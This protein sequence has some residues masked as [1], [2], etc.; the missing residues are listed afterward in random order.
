MGSGNDS[1]SGLCPGIARPDF[2]SGAR[3]QRIELPGIFDHDR[4]LAF[5]AEEGLAGSGLQCG[6]GAYR[7]GDDGRRFALTFLAVVCLP[8]GGHFL[9]LVDGSETVGGFFEDLT[10]LFENMVCE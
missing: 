7:T 10:A 4:E 6:L 5:T 8:E 9:Y 3:L 2:R 1:S